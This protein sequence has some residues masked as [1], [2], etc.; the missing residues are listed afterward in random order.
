[1]STVIT[2]KQ[3]I[4]HKKVKKPQLFIHNKVQAL[5]LLSYL[6][7]SF[8]QHKLWRGEADDRRLQNRP[9]LHIGEGDGFDEGRSGACV[10]H[11]QTDFADM[12][13]CDVRQCR[14]IGVSLFP[15]VLQ[16]DVAGPTVTR[17]WN[18]RVGN[19]E[20]CLKKNSR[21]FM[22]NSKWR[23]TEDTSRREKQ[24]GQWR[25]HPHC[26]FDSWLWRSDSRLFDLQ[27]GQHGGHSGGC[28][29]QVDGHVLSGTDGQLPMSGQ[30]LLWTEHTLELYNTHTHTRLFNSPL[31]S[32]EKD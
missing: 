13:D 24:A 32:H 6:L 16:D 5:Y 12:A 30:P 7:C 25:E 31:D 10:P 27:L 4:T 17:Q 21:S 18:L 1:M 29:E 9:S 15:L 19:T 14:H 22:F 28:K 3:A 23:E 2:W 26:E 11:T 20:N 8:L